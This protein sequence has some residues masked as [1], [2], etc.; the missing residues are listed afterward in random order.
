M[1]KYQK[2]VSFVND[3]GSIIN[4]G[5]GKKTPTFFKKNIALILN[6]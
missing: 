3:N 4:V 2:C 1:V 6:T 5:V